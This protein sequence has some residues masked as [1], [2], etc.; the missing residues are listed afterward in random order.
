MGCIKSCEYPSIVLFSRERKRRGA[1]RPCQKAVQY[2]H[3]FARTTCDR[4]TDRHKA[5]ATAKHRAGRNYFHIKLGLSFEL[6]GNSLHSSGD[7]A[8]VS[9]V[10]GRINERVGRLNCWVRGLDCEQ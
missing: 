6:R 10:V 1:K 9:S 2:S 7:T 4:Q 3:C 5:M 8:M